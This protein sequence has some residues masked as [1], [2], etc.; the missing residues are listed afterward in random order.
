MIITRGFPLLATL[1]L[2]VA[3]L[4]I[5]CGSGDPSRTASNIQIAGGNG[6]NAQ[7]GTTVG[8]RPSVLL[9]DASGDPVSGVRVTF[10]V[11]SGGGSVTGASAVSDANG[12]ATVGS[13]SLG[14]FVGGNTLNATAPGTGTVTFGATA[15]AGA[16]SKMVAV[17]ALSQTAVAGAPV[18]IP[19]AV[20]VTD[21]FDNGIP[22]VQVS[23]VVTVGAGHVTINPAT[24]NANGVATPG[25]WVLDPVPGP[26]RLVASVSLPGVSGT[27]VTFNA[28]GVTSAFNIDVRF[29]GTVSATQQQ[30]FLSARS[31]LQALI[32][33]DL[34][35]ESINLPAGA[36][37][38]TQPALNET[39]DDLV[40]FAR[41]VAID[42]PGMTLARRRAL[43]L[44]SAGRRTPDHRG[45][46]I[47]CG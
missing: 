22:G 30:A 12:I 19:P 28:T 40:I 7:V 16:P 38:G 27:P 1:G 32:L 43:C 46:G 23:F 35:N 10:T 15:T 42:G 34:P 11:A 24:T 2:G 21:A 31:R 39:I 3:V 29:L 13:W 6:Q 45:H 33:G 37:V 8:V 36:C 4:T 44:S 26:N 17:T 41:V 25:S 9:T 18:P 20:K 14:H 47:R 5:G